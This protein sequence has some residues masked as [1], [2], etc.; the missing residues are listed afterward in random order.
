VFSFIR[1]CLCFPKALICFNPRDI[2]GQ[3]LVDLGLQRV[4]C[5]HKCKKEPFLD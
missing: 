3:I 4:T 2:L 5:A 1:L